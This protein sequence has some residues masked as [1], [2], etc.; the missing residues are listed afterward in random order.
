MILPLL[1]SS[2]LANTFVTDIDLAAQLSALLHQ[3]TVIM[4]DPARVSKI[5][6]PDSANRI[7]YLRFLR[8]KFEI[9]D[10]EGVA[11]VNLDWGNHMVLMNYRS[12]YSAE[13]STLRLKASDEMWSLPKLANKQHL[14][15]DVPKYFEGISFSIGGAAGEWQAGS[16]M[17]IAVG[18]AMGLELTTDGKTISGTVNPKKF[19]DILVKFATSR[20][21]G[22][23]EPFNPE[24]FDFAKAVYSMLSDEKIVHLAENPTEQ[25]VEILPETSSL[26]LQGKLKFDAVI[27]DDPTY[28][29][30]SKARTRELYLNSIDFEKLKGRI[31]Y[32]LST[33]PLMS[34]LGKDG[35]SWY[36]F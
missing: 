3:P 30:E 26:L 1:L 20:R 23:R 24:E 13:L 10:V 29:A 5:P 12:Q 28:N 33:L 14:K 18:T 21:A 16:K 2:S 31:R 7:S 34:F 9:I 36:N 4:V 27:Q 25:T 8:R 32:S 19:R 17:A 6:P 22:Q 15:L 11:V 35:H